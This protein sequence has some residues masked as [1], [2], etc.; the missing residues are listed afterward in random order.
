[1]AHALTMNVEGP[2]R[3]TSPVNIQILIDIACRLASGKQRCDVA[4]V[5][6][7]VFVF[8]RTGCFMDNRTGCVSG[9]GKMSGAAVGDSGR[10]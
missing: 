2:H 7:R 10:V 4:C 6:F 1:M 8:L 5:H 9:V 3:S